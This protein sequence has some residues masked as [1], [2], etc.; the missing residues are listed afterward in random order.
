MPTTNLRLI[1][2]PFCGAASFCRVPLLVSKP[3]NLHLGL[4]PWSL[5]YPWCNQVVIQI[6]VTKTSDA[7]GFNVFSSQGYTWSCP[8]P[9]AVDRAPNAATRGTRRLTA[10][11]SRNSRASNMTAP[12]IMFGSLKMYYYTGKPRE[13]LLPHILWI[14]SREMTSLYQTPENKLG[15]FSH[16][17]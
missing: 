13:S 15:C 8:R 10:A 5:C 12:A 3:R 6:L 2:G 4:I 7:V 9:P 11:V 14:V 16:D 17:L 1:L